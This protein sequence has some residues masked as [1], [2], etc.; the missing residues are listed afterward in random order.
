MRDVPLL[1]ADT[2]YSVEVTSDGMIVAMLSRY[3]DENGSGFATL[4]QS[5]DEKQTFSLLGEGY[6]TVTLFNPTNQSVEV[7]LR[8]PE[9]G[10]GSNG[11]VIFQPLEPLERVVVEFNET[12]GIVWIYA[13]EV[14]YSQAELI[15]SPGGESGATAIPGNLIRG[16]RKWVFSEGLFVPGQSTNT[17]SFRGRL[18]AHGRVDMTLTFVID[19][20]NYSRSFRLFSADANFRI[21]LAMEPALQALTEPTSYS[22]ILSTDGNVLPF[23]ELWDPT[24][25][26]GWLSYGVPI[27]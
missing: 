27:P 7:T 18:L 4:G 1:T 13:S 3:G 23:M 19:N 11:S 26:S 2:D 20:S 10:S 5:G 25:G 14:V 24:S 17:L 21:D 22:L 8:Y 6:S 16:E 9:I 12:P 15:W